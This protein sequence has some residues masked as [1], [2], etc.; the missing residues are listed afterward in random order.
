MDWPKAPEEGVILLSRQVFLQRLLSFITAHTVQG[1][2]YMISA[3]AAQMNFYRYIQ[4]EL[5]ERGVQV[6]VAMI[7]YSKLRLR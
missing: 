7:T 4:L 1:G 5:E 2:G 6:G 3:L